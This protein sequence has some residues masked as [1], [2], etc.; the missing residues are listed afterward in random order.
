MEIIFKTGQTTQQPSL[1]LNGIS[2]FV[3]R[4]PLSPGSLPILWV[5]Q[6]SFSSEVCFF[7]CFFKFTLLILTSWTQRNIQ[8]HQ[9]VSESSDNKVRTMD[10]MN[11]ILTVTGY[12]SLLPFYYYIKSSLTYFAS[13]T[14]DMMAE[15]LFCCKNPKQVVFPFRLK[16]GFLWKHSNKNSLSF[17]LAILSQSATYS[18]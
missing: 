10:G 17:S 9:T 13:E 7:V 12:L 11:F 8:A 14:E 6:S 16:D 2:W 4:M 18:A 1:S 15:M 3:I 5:V